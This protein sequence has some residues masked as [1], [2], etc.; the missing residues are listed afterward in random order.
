MERKLSNTD[1][2]QT[3]LVTGGS[4]YI[5]SWAI[6]SLLRAGYTVRTTVRSLKREAAVRQ[7]VA[8][9][10]D[11]ADRLSFFAADLLHDDGWEHAAEG[12]QFV[13]HV[14]S[15]MPAG[16]YKGQ[17]VVRPARDG[18]LRVLK[19][20]AKAG[21]Q[22]VVMTSSTVTATSSEASR[23]SVAL[24]DEAAWTDLTAHGSDKNGSDKNGSDKNGSDKAQGMS[25]YTRA[26]TLAE[27]DAWEFV[28]DSG[29]SMTLAT[30]LAASVQGPV[31]GQDY[32]ASVD[33]VVRLLKGQVPAIP[34]LGFSTVDVRDLVDLHL[35][36]MTMPA[37]SGQRFIGSGDFLWMADIAQLLRQRLGPHAAKV[38]TRLAPDFMVRFAG[39]FDSDAR[40]IAPLL[41]KK[42]E[43][44]TAK[45]E[46]LLGWHA[47]PASEA[48]IDCAESLINL[49]LV[50]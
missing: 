38:P 14:A 31:L 11:P 20:A 8:R 7:A 40:E 21:A 28:R 22:R 24:T 49:G 27:Q 50:N 13:L 45:A 42:N 35:R 16:E 4:G 36:A 41:G 30:I 15:P 17:D 39:L 43:Y 3:V 26:K 29:K 6:V 2:G 12:S 19:A 47:R 23:R 5:G 44:S 48:I 9:Q 10:V 32:S 33:L 46:N 25:G 1:N 34:R 37:A 18:T